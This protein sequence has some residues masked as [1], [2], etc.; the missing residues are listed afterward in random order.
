MSSYILLIITFLITSI[1]TSP[2][3]DTFNTLFNWQPYSPSYEIPSRHPKPIMLLFYGDSCFASSRFKKQ[4][5]NSK[6]I[7]QLSE[8]FTMV[9]IE[10]KH[11]PGL[12]RYRKNGVYYPRVYFISTTGVLLQGV[13][14]P[15]SEHK[16]YF[17]TADELLVAMNTVLTLC[18]NQ[19]EIL[20]VFHEEF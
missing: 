4:I 5:S 6:Q 9:K 20:E 13:N 16:F 15:D 8:E 3:E 17:A 18:T 2:P 14:G 11:D 12:S 19:Q 1:H 10:R 7:I